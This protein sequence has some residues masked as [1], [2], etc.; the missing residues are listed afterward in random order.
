MIA[1]PT[2]ILLCQPAGEVAVRGV[3]FRKD[4]AQS[5]AEKRHGDPPDPIALLAIDKG[6][7]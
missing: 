2:L 6:I 5:K 3:V 1:S 7:Y 4:H